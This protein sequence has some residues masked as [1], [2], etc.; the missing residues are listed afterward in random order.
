MPKKQAE[1]FGGLEEKNSIEQ[2][3]QESHCG[4]VKEPAHGRVQLKSEQ[5]WWEGNKKR[6]E[7]KE[8]KEFATL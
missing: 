6:K 1:S 2:V 8:K 7:R 5:G 3:Q 4:T